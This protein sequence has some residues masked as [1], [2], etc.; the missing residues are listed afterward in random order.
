[1]PELPEVETIKR[2]LQKKIIGLKI[3]EVE[4]L[5]SKSFQADPSLVINHKVIDVIRRAKVLGIQLVNGYTLVFHLKMSGQ[6][7]LVQSEGFRAKN[8]KRFVGGHP[9]K[10]MLGELP[11]TSTRV[12]FTFSDNS[13]LYFNDQRK[14]GW[15]RLIKN[16]ELGIMNYG[17]SNLIGPEPLEK[18][19]NWEVLKQNLLK[20]KN[21]YI[22]VALLDQTVV[23]GVG[24]IYASEACF[25][26]GVD[27]QKK[28]KDLTDGEIKKVALGIIKALS[29]GIEFGGST[30][31]HFVN[32]EGEKGLFLDYAAVYNREGKKCKNCEGV[33][34]KIRS[35]G[36]STFYCKNCQS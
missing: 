26:A 22:K 20:R 25:N 14:F 18:D 27:P 33:I 12:I 6:V 9:T 24:N 10:D 5:N 15:I 32:A 11:N 8:E 21:L 29:E 2:G 19:F 28:V 36:R 34:I 16:D 31:T 7:I 30:R 1:M 13:K 3:T 17:M 23:A 4:I 35:A